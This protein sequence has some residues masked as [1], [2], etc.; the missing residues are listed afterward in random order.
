MKY[1]IRTGLLLI[2]CCFYS[3]GEVVIAQETSNSPLSPGR[4]TKDFPDA[5]KDGHCYLF[6]IDGCSVVA[7]ANNSDGTQVSYLF[8]SAPKKIGAE[9]TAQQFAKLYAPN[10]LIVPFES[11]KAEG[12]LVQ[13]ST[14]KW[15]DKSTD[16]LLG[17]LLKLPAS[18]IQT[19]IW[20][21]K[22][23][24]I[25]VNH[26]VTSGYG[27]NKKRKGVIEVSLDFSSPDPGIVEFRILKGNLSD[28]DVA[29]FIM[30]HMRG[31]SDYY[32][33]L[34]ENSFYDKYFGTSFEPIVYT[35]S[36]SIIRKGRTYYAGSTTK[37]RIRS[38]EASHAST[39]R[40]RFPETVS[41]WP[42]PPSDTE[43]KPTQLAS[44]ATQDASA[45]ANAT[46]V[47]SSS[48]VKNATASSAP[49]TPQVKVGPAIDK[50]LEQAF[51]DYLSTLDSI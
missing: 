20:R 18:N 1:F 46:E 49:R 47:H 50:P 38:R 5:K 36:F 6:Q 31:S 7:S 33:T 9:K 40:F 3:A 12:Y 22:N 25:R 34:S 2:L 24:Y 23:L 37:L 21:G 43:S 45:P 48:P 29:E 11:G 16:G 51:R 19:L 30:L 14:S 17:S 35:S 15:L 26:T 10:A 42:A 44:H 39:A 4:L 28:E 32:N 8:V 13:L 41:S 27:T